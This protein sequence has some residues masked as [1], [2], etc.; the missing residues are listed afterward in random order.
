MIEVIEEFGLVV[1]VIVLQN[2]REV[3]SEEIS[4]FDVVFV[5]FE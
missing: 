3:R 2:M 5:D 1:T 4:P